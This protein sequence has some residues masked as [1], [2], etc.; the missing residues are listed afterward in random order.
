MHVKGRDQ[1]ISPANARGRTEYRYRG[2][3]LRCFRDEAPPNSAFVLK[4]LTFVKQ[5]EIMCRDRARHVSG[6]DGY[7]T[8]ASGKGNVRSAGS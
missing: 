2:Y 4:L 5:M 7:Y 3:L 8:E 1:V 6:R